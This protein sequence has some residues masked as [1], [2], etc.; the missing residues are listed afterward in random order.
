MNR[1]WRFFGLVSLLG[2][3]GLA[4]SQASIQAQFRPPYG[5]IRPYAPVRPFVPMVR[6]Y[7]PPVV[8]YIPPRA[9]VATPPPII[10]Y[11]NSFTYTPL[12]LNLNQV[13]ALNTL[14]IQTQL[15][16]ALYNPF[17]PYFYPTYNPYV[18]TGI[19]YYNPYNYNPY[20]IVTYNPYFSAF[21]FGLR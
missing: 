13:A 21:G 20:N 4:L 15:Y 11:A 3:V 14:R 16:N 8:P 19:P 12:G 1:S 9:F 18:T 2:L 17:N 7:V 5:P 10:P 6:P